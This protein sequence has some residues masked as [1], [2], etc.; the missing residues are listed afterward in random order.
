MIQHKIGMRREQEVGKHRIIMDPLQVV[1]G[2]VADGRRGG[3]SVHR[4][5]AARL[6][7][8]HVAADDGAVETVVDRVAKG[9]PFGKQGMHARTMITF[10]VIL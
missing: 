2:D 4:H 7:E 8:F 9:R 10:L 1:S 3:L 6:A 5:A